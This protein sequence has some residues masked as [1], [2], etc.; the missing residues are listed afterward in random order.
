M[1]IVQ[2]ALFLF[3]LGFVFV[4]FQTQSYFATKQTAFTADG[5]MGVF[6]INFSFGHQN[7]E[8]TIPVR[9]TNVGTSTSAI[10]YSI[11]N[12]TQNIVSG[13]TTGIVLGDVAIQNG[14]YTVPKGSVGKFALLVFYARGANEPQGAFHLAVKGLPFTFDGTQQLSLNPSE[15]QYYVTPSLSLE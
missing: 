6:I 7:H 11:L 5:R 1:R 13:T 9:A 3:A 10:T 4:P 2:F 15:L 8:M 12:S 14:I